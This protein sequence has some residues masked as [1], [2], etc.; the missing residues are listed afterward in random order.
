GPIGGEFTVNRKT[1]LQVIQEACPFIGLAV[2][3]A[4]YSSTE[5]QHVELRMIA[6]EMAERIAYDT[7]DWTKLKV[8]GTI[9]G[10]GVTEGFFLP[11]DYRRMLKTTQLWP[12]N[13]LNCPMSHEPDTDQWLGMEVFGG[14]WVSGVWTLIG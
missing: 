2:P 11:E 7:H 1:I 3:S 6:N 9:T 10:D 12:A 14:P 5:R 13:N 8:L 4:V